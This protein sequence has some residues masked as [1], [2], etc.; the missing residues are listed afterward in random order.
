MSFYNRR[1]T[2]TSAPR[3]LA[4]G[5]QLVP[6]FQA[7]MDRCVRLFHIYYGYHHIGKAIVTKL[8]HGL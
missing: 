7:R 8:K 1:P 4:P 2:E 3:R 6:A 5:A